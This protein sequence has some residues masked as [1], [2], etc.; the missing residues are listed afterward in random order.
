MV[1]LFHSV[2]FNLEIKGA[3]FGLSCSVEG[4]DYNRMGNMGQ[5]RVQWMASEC[6]I[7]HI[8]TMKSDVVICMSL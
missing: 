2:H 8:F 4:K 7:D 3:D 1:L 5:L 6:F